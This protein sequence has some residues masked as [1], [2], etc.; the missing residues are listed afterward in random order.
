[1]D[2]AFTQAVLFRLAEKPNE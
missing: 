2:I 1:M